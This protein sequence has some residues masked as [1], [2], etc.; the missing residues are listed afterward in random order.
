MSP[1]NEH[2]LHVD[3]RL[4][5]DCVAL[6]TWEQE[7]LLLSLPSLLIYVCCETGRFKEKYAN[8]V[9][10]DVNVRK[11]FFFARAFFDEKGN[12]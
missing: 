11:M 5:I 2:R 4:H 6:V 3:S 12:S 9:L 8:C 1:V 10:I 7:F